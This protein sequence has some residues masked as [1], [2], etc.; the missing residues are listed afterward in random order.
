M[1]HNHKNQNN[2][3]GFSDEALNSPTSK[4]ALVAP[5]AHKVYTS[6]EPDGTTASNKNW[7]KAPRGLVAAEGRVLPALR[8]LTTTLHCKGSLIGT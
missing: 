7:P 3:L 6:S 5:S 8:T 1:G 2:L 4:K